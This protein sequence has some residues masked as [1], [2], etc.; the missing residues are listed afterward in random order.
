MGVIRDEIGFDGL[1]MTDDISMKALTG[2]LSELSRLSIDAGCDVILHCNGN[3]SEMQDVAQAAGPMSAQAE[4][5]AD[6]ALA[7]RTT[8]EP[9]DISELLAQR[10]A[11][12]PG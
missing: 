10:E 4:R 8:P 2:T 9:V 3:M 6:A 12:L 11:L 7:M 1:V 5:R